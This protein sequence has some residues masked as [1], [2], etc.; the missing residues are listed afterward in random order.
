ME[1]SENDDTL[2]LLFTA[3]R[4]PLILEPGS[5]VIAHDDGHN[6]GMQKRTADASRNR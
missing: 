5:S 6:D 3:H 2:Q 4:N 1:G